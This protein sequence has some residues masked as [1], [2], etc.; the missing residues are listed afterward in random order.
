MKIKLDK[1]YK[2]INSNYINHLYNANNLNGNNN[3]IPN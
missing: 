2:P 1:Y 3:N